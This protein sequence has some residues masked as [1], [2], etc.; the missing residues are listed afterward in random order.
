MYLLDTNAL[1]ELLKKHPKPQFL[2]HLRR[3]PPEMFLTS[4]ICVMELRHG[5]RRR[6]DHAVFWQRIIHEVLSRVTIFDLSASHGRYRGLV[7]LR[8]WSLLRK[9]ICHC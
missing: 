2:T 3:H 9:S 4:S 5:S 6:E 7:A 1:S 8:L